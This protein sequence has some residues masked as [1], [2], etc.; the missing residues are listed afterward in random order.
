[1]VVKCL[2]ERHNLHSYQWGLNFGISNYMGT[3]DWKTWPEY[4]CS[5]PNKEI[6]SISPLLESVLACDLV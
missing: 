6:E 5:Y 3:V 4:F 2:E 1:M